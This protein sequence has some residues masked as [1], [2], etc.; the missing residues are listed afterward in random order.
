MQAVLMRSFGAPDV[1]EMEQVPT[2]APAAGEA[3]V[4]VGAVEV[5]RT[6]DVATRTGRHPFSQQVTLPHVLGG[7][8]AGVVESVGEGVDAALVGRRVAAM[9]THTCGQCVPC[10]SGREYECADLR[11]VGIHRWGSYAEYA[12]VPVDS[13]HQLP[14]DVSLVDAAALAAT[15]PI[16]LTQLRVVGVPEG[17]TLLV[18]GISGALATVIAALAPGFGVR[19]LGLTRRAALV[20]PS[21]DVEVVETTIPDLTEAIRAATGGTGPDGVIDN[22]GTPDIFDKYFPTLVNGARVVVSGAIGNR[23]EL[24]TVSIPL[25]PFYVRSLS[26]IGVRTATAQTTLDFW[27]LVR[28]GFRL[29]AGLVHE[30]P[31]AD[32][33]LAHAALTEGAAFG[34]TVLV[35]EGGPR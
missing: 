26:L 29:P 11:M 28:G 23:G 22:V 33:G 19:V 32:A 20:P 2:P 14:D 25:A 8:F 30:T 5:S 9:N 35:V 10:R 21:L 13:L 31:L 16:A 6:R 7:D 17:G 4:R 18:T 3:L 12:T 15:G 27:E 34:H 24:P 1:L